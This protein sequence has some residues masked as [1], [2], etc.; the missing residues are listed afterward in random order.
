MI[1]PRGCKSQVELNCPRETQTGTPQT[2][3]EQNGINW[4][5]LNLPKVW[6]RFSTPIRWTCQSPLTGLNTRENLYPTNSHLTTEDLGLTII[7]AKI[8][9][10]Q[11]ALAGLMCSLTFKYRHDMLKH[12][13]EHSAKELKCERCEYTGTLLNLKSHKKQH[14]TSCVIMCPLCNEKFKYRMALWRHTK[15]CRR[16]GSLEY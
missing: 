6:T 16:S 3:P 4:M 5:E 7:M 8:N 10:N 1:H 13:Q 14:D 15:T 9:E 2:C 12:C 11:Y